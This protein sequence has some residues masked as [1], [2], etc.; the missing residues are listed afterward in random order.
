MKLDKYYYDEEVEIIYELDEDETYNPIIF[1]E[2]VEKDCA[3]SIETRSRLDYMKEYKLD[4]Y[5]E[6]C[7]DGGLKEYIDRYMKQLFDSH[8][9]IL[10]QMKT[11]TAMDKMIAMDIARN[12]CL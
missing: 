2:S 1:V 12:D 9:L 3:D 5:V 8:K 11:Q 10:S 6:I 7:E 4:M